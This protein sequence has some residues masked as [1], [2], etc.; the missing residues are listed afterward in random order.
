MDRTRC[1]LNE[2][3]IDKKYWPEGV[4]TAAYVGNRLLANT[5]E[6]KTPYEIIFNKKPDVS[7]LRMYGCSSF[8]RVPE[9]RRT[10]KLHPKSVKGLLIG[11][12]DSGYKILVDNKIIISRNVRF[13]EKDEK[14]IKFYEN[15]DDQNMTDSSDNKAEADSECDETNYQKGKDSD[16]MNI[17]TIQESDIDKL[18]EQE[19][20][21]NRPKRIIKLPSKYDDHVIYVCYA[22]KVSESYE[23]AINCAER[24]RW[25]SA[26][27]D[28]VN[29]LE[30]NETW[31]EV[32]KPINKNIIEV[33]WL[34]KIKTDGTYKARIVVRGFQ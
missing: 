19:H 30:E 4:C 22:N 9:E 26:M 11:Y 13:I 16:K 23:E 6:N 14:A 7:N 25:I 33:N 18:K 17:E 15:E 10:S 2:E 3:K 27:D 1:L 21:K 31:T 34:H 24:R 29:S 5:K 28:E 20:I 12:T 32:D 8:V